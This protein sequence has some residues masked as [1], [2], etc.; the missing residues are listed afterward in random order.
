MS[1]KYLF[2]ICS[3]NLLSCSVIAFVTALC[4]FCSFEV[5]LKGILTTLK[6]LDL[7]VL[8]VRM[9]DCIKKY[10]TA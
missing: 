2:G 6:Y 1:R 5:F 8:Q 3:G 10:L 4:L 7:S 9:H